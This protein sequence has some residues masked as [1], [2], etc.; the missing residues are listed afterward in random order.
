MRK[1]AFFLLYLINGYVSFAQVDTT[2]VMNDLVISG[3]RITIPFSEASRNIQVIPMEEI[4]H[5]PIESLPEILTYSPGVDI[6]QRGPVGVQSDIGIRGGTFEQTLILLNGM[7]LT[8]PQ[9]GH[10]VMNIPVPFDNIGRIEVLKGPGAR[11]Y[12]QNA[13]AGAVNFI[14]E[15]PSERQ[16]RFRGYGGSFGSY[17]GNLSLSLPAGSYRQLISFST[18]GSDGYRYNTDYRIYNGFYESEF[19]TESGKYNLIAGY[20]DKK[21]GANGFY[22]SPEYTEQYEEVS[23][24][25]AGLSYEKVLNNLTVRPRVYWR[26]NRDKYL[27]VRSKPLI[28][29]NLHITNTVNF[30]VNA[31]YKSRLGITGIG[32]EFRK[33]GIAGDWIRGGEESK[34]NLDGF[35]RDNFGIFVEQKAKIGQKFDVT[36]GVYINWNSDFGW[37]AFPG[38][39]IGFSVS[40]DV[41][42]Y[43]NV[44]RSYRVPTFYEQYY[45]SPVEQ[46][47]PNLKPENAMTYELGVRFMKNGLSAEGNYF[48]RDG[49][50][51]IDW[52]FDNSDSLWRAKN[53]QNIIANGLEVSVN[54]D[55]KRLIPGRFPVYRIFGSYNFINQSLQKN[56]DLRSRYTLENIRH[57]IIVGVD[58]KIFG[59]LSNSFKARYIDRIENQPYV[60]IDDRIYY[61]SQDGKF[62]LFIEASNI[63]N[64]QYAEVMTPMPGR[65]F[66]GGVKITFGF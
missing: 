66:R 31:S 20:T 42:I 65:W 11:I 46:G 7:K 44:G 39:D 6:R 24:G 3:N 49:N 60:L 16:I 40:E 57:Q 37:N 62:S 22:A 51:L 56:E 59:R 50:E 1:G 25:F 19:L 26:W 17:G 12:G 21:F 14:T 45:S 32:I 30:E 33:E 9:T 10:H 28:Y 5:F 23:T 8:D 61:M 53:H 35:S 58:H 15:I 48:F 52:V 38:I 18:D 55:F 2:I 4:R 13:F 29:Q 27:F 64:Q 34:S 47:D 54:L 41:R 43:G 63:T 36:P